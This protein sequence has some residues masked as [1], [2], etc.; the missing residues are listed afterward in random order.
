MNVDTLNSS[1]TNSSIIQGNND[2][3]NIPNILLRTA[4][5]EQNATCSLSYFW[6]TQPSNSQFY[7]YFHFAEIEKLQGKQ[8]RLKIDLTG[9]Q[10]A[11]T[12]ATLDYLKPLSLSLTGMPDSGGQLQFSIS[13]AAGSDLPPLLNGFEIYS[14]KEMQNAST[15]SEDGIYLLFLTVFSKFLILFRVGIGCYFGCWNPI[16]R[17]F[18]YYAAI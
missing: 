7:V 12:N 18:L 2:A 14:A 1:V 5:K 6:E 16:D 9:Q 11:T 13:A 3:Y 17:L 10:N 4:A 15:I 8:R